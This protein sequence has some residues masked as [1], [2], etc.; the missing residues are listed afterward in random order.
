VALWKSPHKKT[1]KSPRVPKMSISFGEILLRAHGNFSDK[2]GS[3]I[4]VI[5]DIIIRYYYCHCKNYYSEK[6]R[7]KLLTEFV[8]SLFFVNHYLL[9][10]CG[11]C[12]KLFTG[13][14]A[15]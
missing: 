13:S 12:K 15:W 11:L 6:E 14:I 4:V 10:A 3:V 8:A 1:R 9:T 7:T 2:M 5:N